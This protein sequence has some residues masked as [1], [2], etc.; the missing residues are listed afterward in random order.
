M[1]HILELWYLCEILGEH[2][3]VV[4]K[5]QPMVEFCFIGRL[6]AF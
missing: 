6:L 4:I 3:G 1:I 2:F 5:T